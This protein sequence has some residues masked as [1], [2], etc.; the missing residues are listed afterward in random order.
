MTSFI[1]E[2][3]TSSFLQQNKDLDGAVE[4]WTF[5]APSLHH[6]F[7]AIEPELSPQTMFSDLSAFKQLDVNLYS[8]EQNFLNVTIPKFYMPNEVE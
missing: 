1:N 7:Q 6:I 2:I 4:G 8:V 3:E 5:V